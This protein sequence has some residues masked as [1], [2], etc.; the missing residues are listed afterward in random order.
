MAQVQVKFERI[1]NF[2]GRNG[3]M[4]CSGIDLLETSDKT[5][6]LSPITSKGTIGRCDISVP[7]ESIPALIAA[8][9]QLKGSNG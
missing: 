4:K 1:T 5:V 7:V 9:E 8:L 3:F 2:T 6:M